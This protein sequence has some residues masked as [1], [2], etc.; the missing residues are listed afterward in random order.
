MSE[1]SLVFVGFCVVVGIVV[2]VVCAR[3]A[4]KW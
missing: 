1:W 4:W 2:V 3:E